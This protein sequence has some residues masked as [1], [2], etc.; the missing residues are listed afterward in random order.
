[1][2]IIDI[3][4]VAQEAPIYP[5]DAPLS[6]VSISD[7]QRGDDYND[8]L[9]TSGSHIGTHADAVTHFLSES[10]MTIDKMTLERY[11]GPCRVLTVPKDCILDAPMLSGRLGKTERLVLHTGG[12]SY[13]GRDAAAYLVESGVRTVVTDAWSVAP[14]DN[15]GEIHRILLGAEVA[16]IE[17]VILSGVPDGVYLLSAFPIKYGGCDG[18]PVR[19]VLI[20]I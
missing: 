12:H 10:G 7:M 19:A 14:L 5:G 6:I 2:K 11:Y 18:A 13:L 9:I 8:S 1:M 20:E 17:N 4:R 16:I 15:E 3:T